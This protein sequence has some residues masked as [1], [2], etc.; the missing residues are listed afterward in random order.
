MATQAI[1]LTESGK[2]KKNFLSLERKVEVI[3]TAEKNPSINIRALAELYECGKTQIA[4]IL[5]TKDVLLSRYEAAGSTAN[6]VM[7]PTARAYRTSE[8]AE[9]NKAL[10][11]WFVLAC[12]KNI[13]PAGPQLVEKAKQIAERLGKREFKGSNG[14]LDKW[15]KRYNVKLL[16]ACGESKSSAT[17]RK[18]S[19]QDETWKDRLPELVQGYNKDDIWS[20]DE[21]GMCWKALPSC[22]FEQKCKERKGEGRRSEQRITLAFFVT[23]SGMKERPVVVWTSDNP[24]CLRSIDKNL[25]PVDYYGHGRAWMTTEMVESILTKLNQC[26]FRLNRSI[27][28]LLDNASCHPEELATKFSN[29]RVFFLPSNTRSKVQPLNLGV[30]QSFKVHYRSLFLKYIVSMVDECD[31][32]TGVASSVNILTAIRWVAQAWL[33]VK[34]ETISKCFRKSGVLDNSMEAVSRGLQQ[35]KSEDPLLDSDACLELQ[36]LISQTMTAEDGCSVK[37]YI[38]GDD[39]LPVCA[40][41]EYDDWEDHFFREL[42]QTKVAQ[43]TDMEELDDNPLPVQTY[44]EAVESLEDVQEFLY[45]RGHVREAMEIGLSVDTLV[46]LHLASTKQNTQNN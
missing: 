2:K 12:S 32:A 43:D 35:N 26:L 14:W 15:K 4:Q 18:S 5:K 34:P 25:L 30:I 10:Y 13:Y 39:G 37:E 16:S 44:K 28:L 17:R 22:G 8:F 24:Q 19:V 36:S 38:D 42:G 3:R 46:S 6:H 40:S 20:M 1:A 27:L 29:I 11:D 45:S 33:M 9:V 31:K 21:V 41:D 7:S 23:A